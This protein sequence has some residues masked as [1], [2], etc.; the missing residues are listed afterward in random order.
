MSKKSKLSLITPKTSE[1]LRYSFF[2]KDGDISYLKKLGLINERIELTDDGKKVFSFYPFYGKGEERREYFPSSIFSY[3]FTLVLDDE[4]QYKKSTSYP[5]LST[6]FPSYDEKELSYFINLI[7]SSLVKIN[8]LYI[9]D[10]KY[11]AKTNVIKEFM[12]LE[13]IDRVTYLLSPLLDSDLVSVKKALSLVRYINSLSIN[14]WKRVE[15]EIFFLTSLRLNW[16]ILIKCF[17]LTQKDNALTSTILEEKKEDKAVV[18]SDFSITYSIFND[19]R[20]FF[21]ASPIR[22][23]SI[24][25]WLITKSS[26]KRALDN[27]YTKDEIISYLESIAIF[28]INTTVISRISDWV[29]EYKA[30]EI[31]NCTL[32]TVSQ[33]YIPLF[34]LPDILE[35]VIQSPLPGYYIM[36]SEGEKKWRK[37]LSS[38]GI[39]MLPSTKGNKFSKE[40]EE[41]TLS[42]IPPVYP[43]PEKREVPFC[44]EEFNALLS[45]TK[46]E[47]ERKLVLFNLAFSYPISYTLID[48]LDYTKKKKEAE[49]AILSSSSLVI[50]DIALN[51]YFVKPNRIVDDT[52]YTDS[53]ECLISKIWRIGICD[54]VILEKDLNPLDSDSL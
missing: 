46:N 3:I 4:L 38:Y 29:D 1:K 39:E 15:D 47:L 41:V 25:E 26:I 42:P 8:V 22:M 7:L 24:R 33:R 37:A 32:L 13:T 23:E 28:P 53:G 5:N 6:L 16:D 17:L 20:I 10:D 9:E 12:D 54:N 2:H 19:S 48:G 14:D 31:T 36:K 11:R 51:Y 45:K 35:Y 21:F 50:V 44:E 30:I 40:R 34:S 43:L 52:L 49:K 27:N 18:G